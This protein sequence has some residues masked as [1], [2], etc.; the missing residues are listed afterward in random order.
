MHHHGSSKTLNNQIADKGITWNICQPKK[1]WSAL[2]MQVQEKRAFQISRA[3]RSKD[4]SHTSVLMALIVCLSIWAWAFACFTWKSNSQH[5]WS[6]LN[7]KADKPNITSRPPALRVR[8]GIFGSGSPFSLFAS[9]AL[10]VLSW[11]DP[12]TLCKPP[13]AWSGWNSQ[14]VW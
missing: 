3:A 7:L 2:E 13:V 11:R 8:G 5:W 4:G 12:Q 14:Q 9:L 1:S 10:P 6:G